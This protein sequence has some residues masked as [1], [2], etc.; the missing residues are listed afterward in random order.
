MP[1]R[2]QG[3]HGTDKARVSSI[4][5]NGLNP[6][7]GDKE[8][9]GDGC[10]FFLEGLSDPLKQAEE[11]A[12]FKAWDKKRHE[13]NYSSYAVLCA[14]IQVGEQEFL[15]LTKE[16]GIR[17]LDYIQEQCTS[18]LAKIKKKLRYLDGLL[19]NFAR[20]ENILKI[21]VVKANF[22]IKLRKEDRIYDLDRKTPN[23]TI[24]SVYSPDKNIIKIKEIKTGG[25]Q[26]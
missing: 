11:W 25:I 20:N 7:K 14:E 4:L 19:I 3:F 9:L 2:L 13:N 23:C 5:D 12:I 17:I 8:W 1:I 22:Y 15:D 26:L 16:E 21:D 6:S 10:Y 24:C 18:K